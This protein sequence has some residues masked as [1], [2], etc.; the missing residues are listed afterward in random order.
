MKPRPPNTERRP[1]RLE[2]SI[3]CGQ[4]SLDTLGMK[5]PERLQKARPTGMDRQGDEGIRSQ[6]LSTTCKGSSSSTGYLPSSNLATSH[7]EVQPKPNSPAQKV[8]S[9]PVV[10]LHPVGQPFQQSVRDAPGSFAAKPL[11][12]CWH[13][14]NSYLCRGQF[15][16]TTR[17]DCRHRSGNMAPKHL[18]PQQNSAKQT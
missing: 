7:G 8:V 3:F 9:R 18:H 2:K 6:N 13:S 17:R 14:E 5:S 4:G 16:M 10:P 11:A 1:W 12:G 15:N